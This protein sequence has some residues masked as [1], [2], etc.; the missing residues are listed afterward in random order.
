MTMC[1]R[2]LQAMGWAP[3]QQGNIPAW[4]PWRGAEGRCGLCTSGQGVTGT[5]ATSDCA[6]LG[7]YVYIFILYWRSDCFAIALAILRVFNGNSKPMAIPSRWASHYFGVVSPGTLA[8][9]FTSRLWMSWSAFGIPPVWERCWITENQDMMQCRES[10]A[11]TTKRW[12]VFYR[13]ILERRA[14]VGSRGN[15]GKPFSVSSVL[16]LFSF[17]LNVFSCSVCCVLYWDGFLLLPAS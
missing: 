9:L 5:W 7:T 17:I 2:Q 14:A 11:N 13:G 1:G 6:Y 16:L 12:Y 4:P 8:S 3:P 10:D 15:H